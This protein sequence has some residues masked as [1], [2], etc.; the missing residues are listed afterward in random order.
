MYVFFPI[1]YTLIAVAVIKDL[2]NL[3]SKITNLITLL[4][5]FFSKSQLNVLM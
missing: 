1:F 2:L 3:V 5:V 4:N